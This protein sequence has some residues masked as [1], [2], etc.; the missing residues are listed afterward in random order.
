MNRYWSRHL[1]DLSPYTPGEQPKTADLLKLNTNEHP[2][3]PSPKALAAIKE[4]AGAPLRL[5]PDYD[6][7]ALREAVARLY[8]LDPSQVFAGNG[9]DEVLA[10][11]FNAFFKHP[12]RK[13]LMPD[14][15]YSFYGTYCRMYEVPHQDIPL[16][17]DFSIRASDYLGPHDT[18]PAGIIFANPNAPTGM[19]LGLD[20][21]A[22]IAEG[23]PEC[24]VLVDEAYVDFGARS[25]AELIPTHENILVVHTLSK[26]RSLA[27]L[28][29][30]YA[31]AQAPLIEGL[32]RVK[33]SFN[34][35]PLDRLAQAGAQAAIEDSAYFEEA[36]TTVM[37]TRD[38]LLIPALQA[39]GFE[40]LPSQANFVFARHRSRPGKGLHQALRERNILVRHF[41]RDRIRDFLR[42][43]VGTPEECG[44]LCGT[45]GEIL[46]ET[47]RK[48][49]S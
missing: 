40:V 13:L 28:R 44:R 19:A 4:A 25:A 30:G 11:A 2:Q 6:S 35:Y 15:S 37:R 12:G 43:T 9:S 39:L 34:S 16:A 26:S 29:V 17:E 48:T 42:I 31:M 5:Y 14:I 10:H 46:S 3:G 33:D 7:T 20:E 27:G 36:R 21:I 41:D 38:E 23:N 47:A 18:P 32:V 1:A 49:G 8:G 45:L 22:R 24:V